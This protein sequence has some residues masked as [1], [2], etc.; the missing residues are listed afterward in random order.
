MD[1]QV[2]YYSK[3]SLNT[4]P[5]HLAAT[6]SGPIRRRSCPRH[7]TIGQQAGPHDF[8]D[9]MGCGCC[10]GTCDRCL[11]GPPTIPQ[12]VEEPETVSAAA[13]AGGLSPAG[14][15]EDNPQQA[16]QPSV[17]RNGLETELNSLNEFSGVGWREPTGPTAG[18]FGG[19]SA[20]FDFEELEVMEAVER[21]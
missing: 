3:G 8:G 1:Y 21:E 13:P 17:S 6:I 20:L 4:A 15:S 11:T 14:A 18:T 5:R 9:H 7:Y 12:Q 16:S 2:A 19:S 10:A